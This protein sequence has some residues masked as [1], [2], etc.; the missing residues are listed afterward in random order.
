MQVYMSVFSRIVKEGVQ[1]AGANGTQKHIEEISLCGM[2]LLEASKRADKA[3]NV[4]H[5]A[6]QHTVRDA[7]GDILTMTQ[8][9]LARRA[10]E[11]TDRSGTPFSDPTT[12]GMED[13]VAKGW[14]ENVL[15]SNAM[16]DEE[17]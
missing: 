14:I 13:K 10:V 11:E 8:D 7:T 16:V 12:R 2:F 4:P 15:G 3:F 17:N 1:G 9:L 6:T 5:P